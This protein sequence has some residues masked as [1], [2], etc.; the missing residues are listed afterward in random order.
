[1]PRWLLGIPGNEPIPASEE[2]GRV[3]DSAELRTWTYPHELTIIRDDG[4]VFVWNA[5]SVA[6]DDGTEDSLAVAINNGGVGRYVFA[7]ASFAV[8]LSNGSTVAASGIIS[9]QTPVNGTIAVDPLCSTLARPTELDAY[10]D[11]AI[12]AT[13]VSNYTRALLSEATVILPLRAVDR[14]VD[15]TD[16]TT[17]NWGSLGGVAKAGTTAVP[18]V[19]LPYTNGGKGVRSP[20]IA[21]GTV[22]ALRLPYA[23]LDPDAAFTV[24]VRYQRPP[25]GDGI[26]QWNTYLQIGD[27]GGALGRLIVR[28][29]AWGEGGMQVAEGANIAYALPSYN[30]SVLVISAAAGATGAFVVYADGVLIHSGVKV[31][32]ALS[33]ADHILGGLWISGAVYSYPFMSILDVVVIPRQLDAT[34]IGAITLAL[35]H[36]DTPDVVLM[37]GQSNMVGSGQLAYVASDPDLPA[38]PNYRVAFDDESSYSFWDQGFG[39]CD[40]RKSAQGARKYFGPELTLCDANNAS[41]RVFLKYGCGGM[42]ISVW[43]GLDALV[44]VGMADQLQRGLYLLSCRPR[45]SNII[46]LQGEDDANKVGTT[47]AS[48]A[49]SLTT[50]ANSYRRALH[51]PSLR[52]VIGQL[53]SDCVSAPGCIKLAEVRGGEA[54]FAGPA[55]NPGVGGGTDANA[56][57]VDLDSVH[58]IP[59]DW[60]YDSAGYLDIGLLLAPGMQA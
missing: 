23:W 57:L 10:I 54:S 4:R 11:P 2:V 58:L 19:Q 48:Y 20:S 18:M 7:A 3:T 22:A 28:Q 45:F 52:Y 1:M 43:F 15:G 35:Q 37:T 32:G 51:S 53:N 27:R 24:T 17:R 49:G 50:M 40:V 25:Q 36:P 29:Y 21:N 44:K 46:W 34:E 5:A 33:G 14:A 26:S 13:R 41:G 38:L 12:T 42:S 56:V 39:P 55:G 30:P 31:A 47:V 6:V 9:S 60:H 59:N 8:F 16:I